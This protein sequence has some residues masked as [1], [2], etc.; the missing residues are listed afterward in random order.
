MEAEFDALTRMERSMSHT[1][2]DRADDVD[3]RISRLLRIA[4]PRPGPS[5]PARSRA[6]AAAREVWREAIAARR[7][8]RWFLIGAP[9]LAA[10][11]VT[12]LLLLPGQGD[13]RSVTPPVEVARLIS[14]S[15]VVVN[16]DGG[17]GAPVKAGEALMEGGVLRTSTGQVAALAL[18]GG[19]QLRLNGGATVRLAGERRFTLVGGHI[20]LDSGANATSRLAVETPVGLLRDIG[21]R[22]DVKIDGKA[23]RVRVRE[24]IVRL[25]AASGPVD[26]IEGQQLMAG[27]DRPPQITST[28]TYGEDWDWLMRAAPFRAEG[29]TLEAFLRWVEAEGGRRVEFADPSLRQSVGR[30]VLHGSIEGMTL[31]ESVAVIL[32]ACGLT[33]TVSGDRIIVSLEDSRR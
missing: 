23:L 19:G 27:T 10:A 14:G 15:A 3:A 13:R 26:V 6:R 5:T 32:P 12:L 18:R 2:D 31:E 22:F 30:T 33:H 17:S 29:A 20:Y 8:R 16:A 11:S 24:G 28:A 1:Q 25:D 4:G 9:A 7:R 21:T